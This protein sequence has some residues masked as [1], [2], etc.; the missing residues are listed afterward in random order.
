MGTPAE[1]LVTDLPIWTDCPFPVS[2]GIEVRRGKFE[3]DEPEMIAFWR[4]RTRQ[5]VTF[6]ASDITRDDIRVV[7]NLLMGKG[8]T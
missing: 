7:C 8:Y 6:V 1:R 3:I 5:H 4:A 2:K